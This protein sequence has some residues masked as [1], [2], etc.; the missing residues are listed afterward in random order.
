[1]TKIGSRSSNISSGLNY[2][3]GILGF[4]LTLFFV[5]A[6]ELTATE[7]AKPPI[8][9]AKQYQP[10]QVAK[11]SDYLISEK[12]DGVRGYWDGT[13]M[14]SRSGRI[15]NVPTWFIEGLP[16]YPIDGE[17]WIARNKF[18]QVSA[19]VRKKRASKAEWQQ[20]RFM[21]F[22][23]PAESTPFI[24]RYK[25]ALADLANINPYIQ[26]I[27]Q[28]SL[29]EQAQLDER[30]QSIVAENGEGLM[31][32]HKAA[33]YQVGRSSDIVKLKPFYDAEAV[34]LAHQP[35]KGKYT[36]MMGA[37]LVES[38]QGK[39]FSIGTGFTDEER[40]NPPKIGSIITFKYYG[41]TQKGTPRFA[42]FLR[43][44]KPL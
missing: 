9:L 28:F 11:L 14:L 18:E 20:V 17:L 8:Q 6:A 2:F 4:A 26:V 44:R 29:D 16:S 1:M 5:I 35:G 19:I 24:E 3:L 41:E 25:K 27:E 30:L 31:L 22:D 21:V 36:N 39:Q 7:M 38:Q 42:S 12:L 15:I 32:H 40:R 13:N 34:V 37:L 33:H 43:V 23:L 10:Q